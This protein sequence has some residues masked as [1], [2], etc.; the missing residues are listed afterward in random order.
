MGNT[1]GDDRGREVAAGV[2][3]TSAGAGPACGDTLAYRSLTGSSIGMASSPRA[4]LQPAGRPTRLRWVDMLLP[5]C[6]LAGLMAVLVLP[7]ALGATN[8]G[9]DLVR[10]TVRLSLSW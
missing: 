6:W 8:P 10:N 9:A 3:Q 7:Y 5:G 1:L 4:V 2:A